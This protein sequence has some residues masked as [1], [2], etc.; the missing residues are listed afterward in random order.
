MDVFPL[1]N[2]VN[3]SH[4]LLQPYI[5]QARVLVDMTCGN[6]RDTAFL[7]AGMNDDAVLYAFDIQPCA[8]AATRR[9]IA[10]QHLESKH[11]LYRTGSH[12]Q[13]IADVME[14]IHIVMFNLGYLPSGDHSI[15]TSEE[16]TIRA[17]KICLNKIA[18]NGIIIIAAYP[19]TERGA[20]EQKAVQNFVASLPQK[21]YDASLWQPLNQIHQ[22]PV[23]YSIQKRG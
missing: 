10:A 3:I 12:D 11:I 21:Q 4:I 6:G 8:V 2:A 1:N 22:P 9:Q 18:I 23:L 13:L 20:Q 5:P 16:T 17:C 14:P 7:A 19:G 15:H